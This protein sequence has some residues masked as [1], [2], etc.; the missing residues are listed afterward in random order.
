MFAPPEVF[1]PAYAVG[2][3]EPVSYLIVNICNLGNSKMVHVIF[4]R[5][6]FN[7]AEPRVIKAPSQ[8]NMGVKMSIGE[9]VGCGKNHSDLKSHS[10]FGR[11]Q[12]NRT[13]SFDFFNQSFIKV[14]LAL[15]TI[16]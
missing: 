15:G 8:N 4:W 12:E 2:L 14:D 3:P 11:S 16:L 13:Y 9:F 10:S 1:L 6:G 7:F 5:H